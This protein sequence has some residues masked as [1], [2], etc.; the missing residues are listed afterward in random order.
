VTEPE[1]LNVFTYCTIFLLQKVKH[2]ITATK[3]IT[4]PATM[5]NIASSRLAFCTG[6]DKGL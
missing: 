3:A 4:D 2:K 5:D 1:V 6:V